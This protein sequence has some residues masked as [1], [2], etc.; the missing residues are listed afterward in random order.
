MEMA[1]VFNNLISLL[2]LL[3]LEIILGIDN[4]IFVS[5][6][7][8]RLPVEQQPGAR[9]FGLLLALFTRLLLL[10]AVSWLARFT[11][12][13]FSIAD[14][15]VSGRDLLMF[16]GGLFLLY[17]A[18]LEIHSEFDHLEKDIA[19]KKAST[20]FILVITQ[21]AILDIVFSLDSVMTAV[22]MTQQYWI[23]ATAITLS[24]IVMIISSEPL[25]AF[26][27]KNPSIKMLAVS[28]ILMVGMILIADGIHF[29]VPREYIYFAISF[30]L[31][32]EVLN[33]SLRKKRRLKQDKN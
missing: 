12:P 14:F 7:S 32:V 30:S 17:K 24:I 1:T 20:N 11:V 15:A 33:L 4:L 5:I 9:R 23:M 2:T 27:E 3:F 13:L 25:S 21:I 6:A 29:H 18:T 26:I 22:G 10:A 31:F 8:S 16:F 19:T 28:F